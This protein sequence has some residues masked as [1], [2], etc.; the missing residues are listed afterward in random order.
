MRGPDQLQRPDQQDHR[1]VTAEGHDRFVEP[2]AIANLLAVGTYGDTSTNCSVC[3][4]IS[5]SKCGTTSVIRSS[6]AAHIPA[7][8][9]SRYRSAP[10]TSAGGAALDW[11]TMPINCAVR[12]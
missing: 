8:I 5:A 6:R 11:S 10:L 3:N 2:P 9:G 4:R 12:S 7:Q 1:L